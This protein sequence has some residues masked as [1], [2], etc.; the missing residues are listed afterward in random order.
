MKKMTKF[1]N[2]LLLLLCGVI[3]ITFAVGSS[4]N[5]TTTSSD[6]GTESKVSEVARYRLN[7][8]IYIT[9]NSGKY[10]LKFTKIS[11]TSYRNQFSEIT[12]NRVVLI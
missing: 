9:T 10:R 3:Y 11:E 12:A 4:T 5:V 2:L 1:K 7:E 8:D 6:A